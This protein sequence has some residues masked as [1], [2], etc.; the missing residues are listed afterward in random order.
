M[1]IGLLFL[2]VIS[3]I[4]LLRLLI[5][6]AFNGGKVAVNFS[7]QSIIY[8]FLLCIFLVFIYFRTNWEGSYKKCPKCKETFN[9]KDTVNGKCP[10]CKDVDTIEL[11]EYY[12]KFP[13]EK[14]E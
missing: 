10:N 4:N 8:Q 11:Q 3:C 7:L 6:G 5:Y 1:K 12:K 9:Y 14:R 13:E 2:I